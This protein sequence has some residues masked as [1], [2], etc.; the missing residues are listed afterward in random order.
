MG[1]IELPEPSTDGP[2]VEAAIATRASRR[3]FAD[4]PVTL[5]TVGQL[6]WALQGVTHE[7]DGIDMRAVPS[8]G[9]TYPLVADLEIADGGCTDLEPGCYRYDPDRHA[10]KR[11]VEREIRDELTAAALDQPVIAGAP[12]VVAL[13]AEYDRTTGKY[14]EHGERYVHMEAGHAAQNLHLVCEARGLGSCPVG[15]FDDEALSEALA[16]EPAFEPL[17]LLPFG[18]RPADST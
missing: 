9:A 5:D 14:P 2:S 15:A 18:R 17:Y 7:R 11:R 1:T 10:L 12:A 13:S 16:L 4:E 8:A 3:S 6:L